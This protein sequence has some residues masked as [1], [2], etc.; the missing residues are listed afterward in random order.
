M[1]KYKCKWYNSI[2]KECTVIGRHPLCVLD[3]TIGQRCKLFTPD[4]VPK[5]GKDT[6]AK[7]KELSDRVDK[8]VEENKRLWQELS[9]GWYQKTKEGA[10]NAEW[11]KLKAKH[12]AYLKRRREEAEESARELGKIMAEFYGKA[13]PKLRKTCLDCDNTEWVWPQEF[14]CKKGGRVDR[15]TEACRMFNPRKPTT[16][17]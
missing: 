9:A 6:S 14:I 12:E 17:F 1:N 11:D 15:D 5:E 3:I 10:E 13:W 2:K 4:H 16:E 8:L 7:I